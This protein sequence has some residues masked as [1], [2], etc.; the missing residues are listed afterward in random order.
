[1][2]GGPQG[3]FVLCKVIQIAN[4]KHNNNNNNNNDSNNNNNDNDNDSNKHD[5]NTTN[6]NDMIN[7]K[8]YNVS[9]APFFGTN[10]FRRSHL[11]STTCLMQV[12]FT[13]L[14]HEIHRC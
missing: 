14:T 1:M 7:N 2:L 6:N 3:S 4:D 13:N 11:S 5:I 9:F 12:F 8:Q 10:D